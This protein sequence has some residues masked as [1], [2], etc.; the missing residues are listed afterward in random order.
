MKEIIKVLAGFEIEVKLKNQSRKFRGYPNFYLFVKSM[1]L[2][3]FRD[4]P[5]F[6]LKNYKRVDG[7][8]TDQW[9]KYED[10]K[11]IRILPQQI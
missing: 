4:S 8:V 9:I 2:K 11:Y 7:L 5:E 6:N 10:I 3:K 1:P